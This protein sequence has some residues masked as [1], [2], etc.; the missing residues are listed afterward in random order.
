MGKCEEVQTAKGLF[1]SGDTGL[2]LS[3]FIGNYKGGRNESFL[4]GAENETIWYDYDLVSA[5]TTSM[6]KISLPAYKEGKLIEA[7]IVKD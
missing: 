2:H 5:Y 6:A 4:Y 7:S 3:S 1:H